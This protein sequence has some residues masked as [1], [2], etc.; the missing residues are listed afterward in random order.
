MAPTTPKARQTRTTQTWPKTTSP[1]PPPTQP[2]QPWR[3][4]EHDDSRTAAGRRPG[5]GGGTYPPAHHSRRD[6]QP[7]AVDGL[8]G[9]EEDAP[10]PGAVLRRHHPAAAVHGH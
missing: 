7:D 8:A 4:S 2:T 1:T 3:S 10:Q 6:R 5:R 9:A